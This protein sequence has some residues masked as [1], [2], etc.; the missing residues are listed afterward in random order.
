MGCSPLADSRFQMGVTVMGFAEH[1]GIYL[2]TVRYEPD[3][4]EKEEKMNIFKK[5]SCFMKRNLVK[6]DIDFIYDRINKKS[7]NVWTRRLS[8]VIVNM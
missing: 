2:H 3:E 7:I 6:I 1:F 8:I 4:A 5:P